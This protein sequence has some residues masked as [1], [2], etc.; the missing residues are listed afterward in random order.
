M[1]RTKSTRTYITH[2]AEET[3]SFGKRL[4]RHLRSGNVVLLYGDL[5]S[6]KTTLAQ[7]IVR[8]LGVEQWASSPSF[9]LIN[10]YDGRLRDDHK[11]PV[12]IYHCDFYR[13][14]DPDE[15]DTLA[16]DEV[17]YGDGIALVEWPE[18]AEEW[19]PKEAMRVRIVRRGSE[20]RGIHMG[21]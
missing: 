18:I 19:V 16:L 21:R 12:R 17:F 9:T 1:P 13:L 6:G 3:R 11:T 5:G 2:S 14:S 7:G 8:G 20:T 4:A 15:L 10:Q